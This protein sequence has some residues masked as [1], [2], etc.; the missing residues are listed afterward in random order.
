[1][2]H[3]HEGLL[4]LNHVS[5][6]GVITVVIPE[7]P[8]QVALGMDLDQHTSPGV[9]EAVARAREA[10]GPVRTPVVEL[11]QGGRK[12]L[13]YHAIRDAD[14]RPRRLVN[15]VFRID[16]LVATCLAAPELRRD[17]R[18][19]LYDEPGT[20]AYLHDRSGIPARPSRPSRR[21]SGS[22]TVRGP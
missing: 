6:D 20:D 5:P 22:S 9:A 15:C 2:D 3:L 16:T 8:N 10:D 13:F 17:Y 19:G 18:F 1:M 11:Y 12:L 7:A 21:R 14:G 4:A